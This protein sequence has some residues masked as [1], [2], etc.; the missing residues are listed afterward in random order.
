MRGMSSNTSALLEDAVHHHGVASRRGILERLFTFWF[1]GFVYSQIWEDPRVDAEALELK[2]ESRILTI[3]SGGCNV[4]NYLIHRPARIAVVDL[5]HCHLSL[6]RLKLAAAQRLP[7]HAAFYNMFGQGKHPHNRNNY[8][9]HIARHLDASSRKYW[10][11]RNVTAG[12]HRRRIDY[13]RT[14]LYEQ[15]KLGHFLRFTHRVA[16]IMR[17]RP[18]A[19][20]ECKT[21][22]EQKMYFNAVIEPLFGHG[23]VRWMARQPMTVF[24]LGIPPSQHQV[25][26]EETN[27]ELID[28][29]RQRLYK[30]ACGFPISDNYFAWQA[31][32]RRYDHKNRRAIPDYLRAEHFETIRDGVPRVETRLT[33]LTGYLKTCPDRSLNRFV[34]LDSQDWMPP[35]IIEEMWRE[36]ARVGQPGTRIIFRTAGARSPIESALPAELLRRF[37]YD[38]ETSRRLHEQDRSAI[39]GG[40]HLY[41]MP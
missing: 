25:M 27:G 35:A 23:F 9:H 39:Y 4:L 18:E 31:F 13:F 12:Q 5:N 21:I 2:P 30:L 17:L 14:G 28:S 29:Y 16:K 32:G 1:R 41:L 38:R 10:E 34:L 6:C 24:S 3:S 36:V 7:D 37:V 11:S 40:F 20:L 19:L 26:H 15:S 33:T 8:R 22:E